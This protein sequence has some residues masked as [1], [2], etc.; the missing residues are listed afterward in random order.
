MLSSCPAY[1]YSF[2]IAVVYQHCDDF[3]AKARS[4]PSFATYRET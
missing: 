1:H 3:R 2:I 4:N